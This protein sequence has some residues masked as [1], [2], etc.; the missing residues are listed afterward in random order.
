MTCGSEKK[1]GKNNM[2][3]IQNTLKITLKSDLCAGSGFSYA[4]IIDSDVSYDKYGVPFISGRRLK[5]CMREAAAMIK[6]NPAQIKRVFGASGDT[7]TYGIIIGNAFPVGWKK[8]EKAITTLKEKSFEAADYLTSQELLDQFTMVQAQTRIGESGVAQDGSLRFTR[9]VRQNDFAQKEKPLVFEAPISYTCSEEEKE[10]LEAEL[11]HIAKATRHIGMK[12]NRGL[13]NIQ[14]ELGK[15]QELHSKVEVKGLDAVTE[16][17]GKAQIHYVIQNLEPLKMSANDIRGSVTYISGAS[18]L[19]AMAAQY[20]KKGTAEDEA[21]QALFLDGQV[22][23]SDLMPACK[24]GEDY[25]IYYPAPQYINRL[26]KTKKL[27][28]TICNEGKE[29][30]KKYKENALYCPDNGNQPKKLK[31]KY[32][33][34]KD[35]K[36]AVHEVEMEMVYHHNT[37]EKSAD[38]PNGLLY[39]EEVIEEGQFFGG[40]ILTEKK[41]LNQIL[42]LLTGADLRFGK[43]KSVQYG[44]CHLVGNVDV[45][46]AEENQTTFSKDDSIMV[47]LL[48]DAVFMDKK[49]NY[50]VRHEKVRQEIARQ[51]GIT[52]KKSEAGSSYIGDYIQTKELNGYNTKWNLK[53]QSVPAIAAGS[54]FHFVLEKDLKEYPVYIGER[55]AEGLGRISITNIKDFCY[56]VDEL[57]LQDAAAQAGDSDKEGQKNTG[58]RTEEQIK[59]QIEEVRQEL[60]ELAP[61]LKVI[62]QKKLYER[63]QRQWYEKLQKGQQEDALKISSATLG[64]VKLMLTEAINEC[65]GKTEEAEAIYFNMRERVQSI[66]RSEVRDELNV[67]LSKLFGNEAFKKEEENNADEDVNKK[68]E[69]ST[70]E[71]KAR[72]KED[73]IKNLIRNKEDT[74]KKNSK[75]EKEYK[76]YTDLRNWYGEETAQKLTY[77]L[78]YLCLQEQLVLQKYLMKDKEMT[79]DE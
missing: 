69:E 33:A 48:S 31:G 21:F 15:G 77:E 18:V 57:E 35:K 10:Q 26:K 54:A 51:L 24:K 53:K 34:C 32:V 11:L 8:K 67:F 71:E 42:E 4:G 38:R 6:T 46:V 76:E 9:V 28:N 47:T 1:R 45:A 56:C 61:Q 44:H 49:G 17:E 12:R 13:G 79:E 72:L 75:G 60:D 78:W 58:E 37:T 19:G 74:S 23:Y 41:W 50:T 63:M 39:S 7:G 16:K 29:Q 36:Y 30:E 3:T 73:I 20:L 64:R 40:T 65:R 59:E 22:C 14:I 25:L 5:G 70:A 43:S 2:V 55:N 66:K 62:L 52:D 68:T 27:V